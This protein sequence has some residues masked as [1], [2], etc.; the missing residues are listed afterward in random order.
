M[1]KLVA[2][3]TPDQDAKLQRLKKLLAGE[4]FKAGKVLIFTQY[5]DTAR[6]LYDY[7]NPGDK[8]GLIDAAWQRS[9]QDADTR[10]AG[11]GKAGL[12]RNLC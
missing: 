4:A 11:D 6:Y 8:T 2:P 7:L 5:A 10:S 12:T 3:I 1:Q 9:R